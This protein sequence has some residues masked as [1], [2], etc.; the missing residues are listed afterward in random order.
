[1]NHLQLSTKILQLLQEEATVQF[2][3]FPEAFGLMQ[4][5]AYPLKDAALGTDGTILY[6]NPESLCALFLQNPDKLRWMYLH[7]VL[8]MLLGHCEKKQSDEPF[9][10][11]KADLE[12]AYIGYLLTCDT[13]SK[14]TAQHNRII[15]PNE[16]PQYFTDR[17]NLH[18]VQQ[19]K[20]HNLSFELLPE[21]LPVSEMP[22]FFSCDSHEMWGAKSELSSSDLSQQKISGSVHGRGTH[23]NP[24]L[25]KE[26]LKKKVLEIAKNNAANHNGKRGASRGN[27]TEDA[28]LQRRDSLDYHRFLQ[29]FMIPREEA[30]LDTDSFDYIPYH[31]GLSYYGN[32]PFIEPLEYKEVNRLD[33]LAIAIDTSGSCS[34]VIV[35]RFLEETWNI[36]RQKENFF[37]KMR[38]HLIQCDCMVQEHRIFTSVEEWEEAVPTLQI[39]GHGDTDFQPVFTYLEKLIQKGEIRQLRGLLFFTDGDGIFPPTA[40]SFD[41]AF[42]FLNH[43]TEKHAIPDWGIRLNLNLP[44]VF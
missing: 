34:G 37:S 44:D 24:F 42:V 33:E 30:I 39:H 35:R 41:T 6:Y 32:L 25:L 15:V 10:P 29:R 19:T 7:S 36:L 21:L 3:V 16:I 43:E 12:N 23:R 17:K 38:L 8:H 1:M 26:Q 11:E 22:A 18:P 28:E 4:L 31:Y 13:G 5:Q 9:F 40:P 14:K 27:N 20:A 2:P